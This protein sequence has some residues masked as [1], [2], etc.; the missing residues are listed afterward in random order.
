MNYSG[1]WAWIGTTKAPKLQLALYV[2][3][4]ITYTNLHYNYTNVIAW[5]KVTLS[6]PNFMLIIELIFRKCM[7]LGVG[8]TCFFP[9]AITR[10]SVTPSAYTI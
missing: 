3:N 9:D 6:F 7:L 4:N 1:I 8:T 5:F 2:M 10:C